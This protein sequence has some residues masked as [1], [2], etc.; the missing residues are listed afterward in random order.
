MSVLETNWFTIYIKCYY[1]LNAFY[2]KAFIVHG[3]I[4]EDFLSHP[5]L[6]LA[7]GQNYGGHSHVWITPKIVLI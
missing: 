1:I 3:E 7:Q 5:A 6:F 2:S 4:V